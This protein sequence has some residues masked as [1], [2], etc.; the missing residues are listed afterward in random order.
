MERTEADV[1]PTTVAT[2]ELGLRRL[3]AGR[4]LVLCAL[5]YSAAAFAVSPQNYLALARVYLHHFGFFV[6]VLAL[7]LLAIAPFLDR[8]RPFSAMVELVQRSAAPLTAFV[9]LSILFLA[10]F[11]TF[12]VNI[13][14]VVPFYADPAFATLDEWI[15]GRDPWVYLHAIDP[16]WFSALTE[17]VYMT[18][19]FFQWFAVALFAAFNWHDRRSRRYLWA[20]AATIIVVGTLLATAFASVG[21]IFYGDF[22]ESDRFAGLIGLL[23]QKDSLVPVYSG[24]LLENFRN[25]TPALGTG[26]S[27]MPSVHVAVATLNALYLSGFG[28]WQAVVGWTFALLILLGS[29]YTG[30]HYALDGYLSILVVGVIWQRTRFL[31]GGAPQAFSSISQRSG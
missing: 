13:P 17:F 31:A 7:A 27:A 18:L 11:T 28:R 23:D 15:H 21:P 2:A 4:A 1:R 19:W 16:G 29:V 24:Y 14:D 3:S 26:I 25:G 12:K 9:A 8:R 10:G 20:L 6:P 5:L 30:W 22:L